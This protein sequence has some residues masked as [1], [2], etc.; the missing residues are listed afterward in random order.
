MVG[1][2]IL[3]VGPQPQ[4]QLQAQ[5]S[6]NPSIPP[7]DPVV[8]FRSRYARRNIFDEDSVVFG[9]DCKTMARNSGPII[10][11]FCLR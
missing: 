11:L 9:H 7:D 5:H 1:D 10:P 4:P 8:L 3:F 6:D 2:E